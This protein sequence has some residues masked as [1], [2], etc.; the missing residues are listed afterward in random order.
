MLSSRMSNFIVMK[1]DCRLEYLC[2][3][4][5]GSCLVASARAFFQLLS[6]ARRDR[7]RVLLVAT[8]GIN[9]ENNSSYLEPLA[10]AEFR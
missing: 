10:V 1:N 4:A 2:V 5:P 8:G 9:I 7:K 6:S 3:L